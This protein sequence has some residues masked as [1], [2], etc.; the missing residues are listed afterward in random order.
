M[1]VRRALVVS[2]LVVA[3][4]VATVQGC[5]DPT[6]V[7]LELSLAG[8]A[9]CSEIAAGTAITVGVEPFDTETRVASGFVTARTTDC[10]PA[11]NRIGTLVVTPSDPGK[12]S[13]VVVVGYKNNDPTTCRPPRYDG[14]IVA[15]RRFAF[16]EHTRLRMPITIDPDCAGV[17]CDAFSTCN[18]GRCFDSDTSCSGEQ[19]ENP[20]ELSDGGLDEAGEVE[21]DASGFDAGPEDDGGGR[22]ASGPGIRCD[23]TV[24][25]CNGVACGGPTPTCCVTASGAQCTP[26]CVAVDQVCCVDGSSAG[27][28][29]GSTCL[30]AA[31]AAHGRCKP[32]TGPDGGGDTFCSASELVTC[33]GAECGGGVC[34]GNAPAQCTGVCAAPTQTRCCKN[35]Q[36]DVCPA[37]HRCVRPGNEPGY[38]QPDSILPDAGPS[39]SPKCVNNVLQCTTQPCAGPNNA[40]CGV[41]ATCSL[42]TS[43]CPMGKLKHCCTNADCPAGDGGMGSCIPGA[44]GV[45]TCAAIDVVNPPKP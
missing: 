36:P 44:N 3:T 37:N 24:P 15:R 30:R 2:G 26:A 32:L 16:A 25:V 40:C 33:D 12:A 34:C 38:C 28:P 41:P 1:T 13:V 8:E 43:V 6:Q 45:G 9:H 5:Q 20:G 31:G 17:P 11:T 39:V 42:G 19:C 29:S 23:G 10:D 27:C 21:P 35:G 18:K 7:T 4:I 22:D 14:C